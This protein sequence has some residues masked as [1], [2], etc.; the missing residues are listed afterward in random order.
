MDDMPLLSRDLHVVTYATWHFRVSA[1]RLGR[2][3]RA[4]GAD[5]VH[6]YTPAKL[7]RES[8]G[9]RAH[10][11][12][13]RARRGAG[14]WLWKPFAILAVLDAV[15][16]GD[17]VLYLDAGTEVASSLNPLRALGAVHDVVL[18]HQTGPHRLGE[19]TKR[20]CFVL[21]DADTEAAHRSPVLC[22]G[23]QMYRAGPT[24][25]QFVRK[26]SSACSDPRVLSDEPNQCGLDNLSGF[27]DHRHDQSVLSVLAWKEGISTFPDPSQFG[28]VTGAPYARFLRSHRER[29]RLRRPGETMRHL[30]G[31]TG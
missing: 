23:Y 11:R 28:D 19:W 31:R 15:P 26:L 17:L 14:Y 16:D 18:F 22:G 2:G 4:H 30:L 25:R 13:L 12:L 29:I 20:D 9:L 1:W 6:L 21:L 24:A 3:A 5:R 27:V 8:D 7:L 10:R